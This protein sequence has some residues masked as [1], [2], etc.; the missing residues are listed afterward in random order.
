MGDD[1]WMDYQS[2]SDPSAGDGASGSATISRA[3]L[4]AVAIAVLTIVALG[5]YAFV[6]DQSA[7]IPVSMM[8]RDESYFARDWDLQLAGESRIR[9]AADA[10]LI[11]FW[12]LF[13]SLDWG[14]FGAQVASTVLFVWAVLYLL[15]SAG[16][17]REPAILGTAIV[18][19]GQY[20]AQGVGASFPAWEPYFLPRCL[21]YSLY[22]FSLGLAFRRRALLA[23]LALGAA[24]VAHAAVGI[25]GVITSALVLVLYFG[26]REWRMIATTLGVAALLSSPFIAPIALGQAVPSTVDRDALMGIYLFRSPYLKPHLWRW[27]HWLIFA[28]VNLHAWYLLR[29][30][31][32]DVHRFLRVGISV[33]LGLAIAQWL[34]LELTMSTLV[35]KIQYALRMLPVWRVMYLVAVILALSEEWSR[36]RA[37]AFV[38]WMAIG[39]TLGTDPS[40]LALLIWE[41]AYV[42]GLLPKKRWL[43]VGGY[44]A[45][46]LVAWLTSWTI[47]GPLGKFS[48]A[49]LVGPAFLI[50]AVGVAVVTDWNL[51]ARLASRYVPIGLVACAM[52]AVLGVFLIKTHA[53]DSRFSRHWRIARAEYLDNDLTRIAWWARSN[54]PRDALFLVPPESEQLRM[55]GE[56][57]IFVDFK[58]FVLNEADVREWYERIFVLY[59]ARHDTV[60]DPHAAT[61]ADA[62]R[63]YFD[64]RPEEVIAVAKAYRID[65]FL[66]RAS[67]SY[68]YPMV[69]TE[70]RWALYDLSGPASPR[71][72]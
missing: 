57:S 66:T 42:A 34:A 35:Y 61:M 33:I 58:S 11:V 17:G 6:N 67:L 48:L 36:N 52:L 38:R 14:V 27:Q 40:Y 32:T 18:M 26:F 70:G 5:Y 51:R 9:F 49:R 20:V 63:S 7:N 68:P 46:V 1:G 43:V 53:P 15:R 69:R 16:L 4:S 65:Y 41:I 13:C 29:G 37:L 47:L 8:L 54:T 19:I 22:L 3:V 28:A 59:K 25:T 50:A 30:R 21:G 56:R 2:H 10:F 44:V 71:T 62:T 64:A 72:D 39:L 31:D 23:G 12:T 60:P 24:L 55:W 45:A